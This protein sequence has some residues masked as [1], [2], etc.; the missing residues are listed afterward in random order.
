MACFVAPAGVAVVATIVQQVVKKKEGTT[1]YVDGELQKCVGKWT[2]RLR[3]L[4]T[5]LW[6]G[7]VLLCLEHIWH[8]EVVPW[9]PFLTAM[10]TPGDVGPMLHEI[11]T[12]GSTMAVV[13]LAA[14]GIMIGIAEVLERRAS[15]ADLAEAHSTDVARGA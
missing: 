3:W 12:Y 13:I 1:R 7:V 9:P 4:N 5:M 6:G 11:A 8:G 14:W 2:R 10:N 15:A